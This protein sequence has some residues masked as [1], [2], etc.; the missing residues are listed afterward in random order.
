MPLRARRGARLASRLGL[1]AL[2]VAGAGGCVPSTVAVPAATQAD[3]EYLLR[4]GLVRGHLL[5]G[6]A[7]LA[8]GERASAQSH[9]KHPQDEL[10]AGMAAELAERGAEGFAPQLAAHAAA[11]EAGD[12]A[13][14]QAAYDR[15]VAAISRSESVVAT[16]PSLAARV[17]RLLLEE[18]A[19]E[20][21]AGVVDGRLANAHE[22]Q[23]AYGFA[24]VALGM[25]LATHATLGGDDPDRAVFAAIADRLAALAP[26]WP[27]LMPPPRLD[28]DA[29]RLASA[30]DGVAKDAL[31]LRPRPRFR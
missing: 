4:L 2:A 12:A 18:A 26:M 1:A 24:Q 7:L 10:Y 29:A 19:V 22:Y 27:S 28:A 17:I 6:H 8:L 31:G 21:A 3:A 9:A 14:A 5:V 20:Y 23:D 30:A 11:V 25:A 16:S 13:A 15:L